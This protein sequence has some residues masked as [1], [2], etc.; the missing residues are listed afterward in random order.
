MTH[1][2]G[3]RQHV[4]VLVDATCRIDQSADLSAHPTFGSPLRFSAI[5]RVSAFL[6]CQNKKRP[7]E[8][9]RPA[10]VNQIAYGFQIMSATVRFAGMNGITCSLYGTTT[11]ST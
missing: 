10:V 2:F 6:S 7:G 3:L 4:A 11:S 5:L 9:L 1:D 8:S